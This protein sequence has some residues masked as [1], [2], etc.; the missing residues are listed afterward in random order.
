MKCKALN[1]SGIN[2]VK[3]EQDKKPIVVATR[4]SDGLYSFSDT[5]PMGKRKNILDK[6]TKPKC[7]C[8]AQ[9]TRDFVCPKIGTIKEGGPKQEN[10]SIWRVTPICFTIQKL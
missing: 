10:G 4:G 2:L 7:T 1:Q 3:M 5:T 8:S 6:R 9:T